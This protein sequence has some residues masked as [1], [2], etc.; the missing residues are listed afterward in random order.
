MNDLGSRRPID[1]EEYFNGDQVHELRYSTGRNWELDMGE[2]RYKSTGVQVMSVRLEGGL[3]IWSDLYFQ[4][5]LRL[6]VDQSVLRMQK[7]CVSTR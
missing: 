4:L 2:W 1:G 5:H 3:D 6:R 7:S